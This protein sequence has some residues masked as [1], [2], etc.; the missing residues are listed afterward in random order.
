MSIHI[1]VRVGVWADLELLIY[2]CIRVYIYFS[3]Y[4]PTHPLTRPF[5]KKTGQEAGRGPQGP[6]GRH[7]RRDAGDSVGGLGPAGPQL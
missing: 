6:V 7:G 1:C 2:M 4:T 5:P 3:I